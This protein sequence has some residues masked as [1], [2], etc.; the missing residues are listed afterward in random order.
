MISGIFFI[1]TGCDGWI[2]DD[3]RFVVFKSSTLLLLLFLFWLLG[4]GGGFLVG[5]G[6]CGDGVFLI[7]AFKGK[8]KTQTQ[9]Q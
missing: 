9:T 6:V 5:G 8:K 4:G 3:W 7:E 1:K 2:S